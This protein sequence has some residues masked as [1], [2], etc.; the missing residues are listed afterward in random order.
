M[1]DAVTDVGPAAVDGVRARLGMAHAGIVPALR[2][3]SQL[4]AGTFGRLVLQAGYFFILANTLRLSE[5]GIFASASAAGMMIGCFSGFG[6]GAFAFRAAAGRR[7]LLGRYMALFY[8]SLAFGVPLAIVISLPLYFALFAGT[9]SLTAFLAIVLVEVV[10]WR[11]AEVLQQVVNGEGRFAASSIIITAASAART[12][13]AVALLISGGGLEQ[14]AW[15]YFSANAVSVAALWL[16]Y[17]PRVRLHWSNRLLRARLSGGLLFSVSYFALVAQGQI[18]KLIVLSLVDARFAGLYAISMRVIEFTAVLFRSFYVLY[19]RKLFSQ[20]RPALQAG[21]TLALEAGIAILAT[22]CFAALLWLL[23][24]W[25]ALLGHNVALAAPVFG[26]MLFLPAFKNLLEFH[27][28][29]FFVHQRYLLRAFLSVG[30]VVLSAAAL[31]LLL[32][33]VSDFETLGLWLNGVYAGLYAISAL[34]VYRFVI[35]K[36]A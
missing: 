5:M 32:S 31:V 12:V 4:L 28:E 11:L 8:A 17:Q 19:T 23:S 22:L 26:L 15:L 1:S 6:F 25:P 3:Y 33:R 2:N 34:V 24:L 36:R 16:V 7:Q 13:A 21:R 27:S 30:L 29:I 18:D 10:F 35:V 14:W 20:G 9:I